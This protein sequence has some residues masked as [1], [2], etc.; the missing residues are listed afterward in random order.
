MSLAAATPV[1]GA[2]HD[3]EA[4]AIKLAIAQ[5]P[6]ALPAKRPGRPKKVAEGA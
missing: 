4:E 5:Q 6:V 2:D 1:E 3:P